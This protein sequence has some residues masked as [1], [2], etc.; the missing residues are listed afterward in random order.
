MEKM[1][2]AGLKC[3]KDVGFYLL[4]ACHQE[5]EKVACT[6]AIAC[7]TPAILTV[8][9]PPFWYTRCAI[10]MICGLP[11]HSPIVLGILDSSKNA[12]LFSS[13]GRMQWLSHA[14]S[15]QRYDSK[16]QFSDTGP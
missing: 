1:V 16:K 10:A 7:A 3:K 14:M 15:Y 9:S 13:G 12:Q 11:S 8:C 2:V 6:K 4:S 5:L